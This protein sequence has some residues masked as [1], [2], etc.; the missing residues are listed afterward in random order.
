MKDQESYT[1]WDFENT[2]SIDTYKNNG[3][4]FLQW[5]TEFV[6]VILNTDLVTTITLATGISG[7]SN[8]ENN[9][10]AITAKGLVWSTAPEPKLLEN[11]AGNTNMGFGLGSFT[12]QMTELTANTTYYVRAYAANTIGTGYGSEVSFTTLASVATSPVETFSASSAKAGGMIPD[13]GNGTISA[14]GVVM[15]PT[16]NTP[17]IDEDGVSKYSAGSGTGEFSTQIEYLAPNTTYYAR[18]YAT[19]ESGTSYGETVS[20]TTEQDINLTTKS[21]TEITGN[22]AMSGGSEEGTVTESGICWN[23]TGNP[24]I[25]DDSKTETGETG[26]NFNSEIT[27]LALN[28]TYYIRAYQINDSGVIYGDEKTFT[29]LAE[30]VNIRNT[31]TDGDGK[32]NMNFLG[33]AT[34]DGEKSILSMGFQIATNYEMTENMQYLADPNAESRGY[35]LVNWD[36]YT[37]GEHAFSRWYILY[38]DGSEDF[39]PVSAFEKNEGTGVIQIGG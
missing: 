30:G 11:E 37:Y 23:T 31:D 33:T 4:P 35:I 14:R 39:G 1:D 12:S 22:S 19:N 10:N 34:P 7:G 6:P 38:T 28:T 3:Y 8:I 16:D 32:D 20:F 29:T 2:W 13:Q 27:G 26:G 9:G 17:E 25:D 21:A 15:S 36:D 24:N 5:Q 18:A